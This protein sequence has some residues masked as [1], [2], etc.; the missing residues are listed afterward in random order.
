MNS[1]ALRISPT[2]AFTLL[3]GIGMV[4]LLV[5]AFLLTNTER[6]MPLQPV[7]LVATAPTPP[8][9]EVK[10]PPEP[11]PQPV[12]QIDSRSWTDA[13]ATDSP[14]G[15]SGGPVAADGP[16]GLAEA[17][18]GGSDA[19]GLAGRPGGTELLLTGGGGGGGNAAG[20]FA[21]FAHELET[22]M[23]EELNRNDALRRDCYTVQVAVRLTSSGAVQEVKIARSTGRRELDAEIRRALESLP[24]LDAAP[25]TDIPWPV[26]LRIVSSRADCGQSTKAVGT[27]P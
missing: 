20:R 1:R 25:P 5:R 21:L 18:E 2:G 11:Q 6:V 24:P 10:K 4:G 27:A 19:F 16:L 15:P 14:P 13:A 12:E 7:H 17:G 26:S 23:Q 22:H 8:P 9:P 3:L